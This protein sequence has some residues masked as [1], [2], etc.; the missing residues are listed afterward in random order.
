[1]GIIGAGASYATL[2]FLSRKN[3]DDTLD[4]FACHGVGGI[5]GSILTGVFASAT[6]NPGSAN[7][8]IYGNIDLMIPQIE[9]TLATI[10]LAGAGTALL[11]KLL[12]MTVGIRVQ[13]PEEDNLDRAQ[14]SESAYANLPLGQLV[15]QQGLASKEDIESCLSLQQKEE[16][17]K[18]LG[19]MLIQRGLLTE[20]LLQ[21]LLLTQALSH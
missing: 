13:S 19:S 5:V 11:L 1:M 4:V 2:R 16:N 8:L 18:P 3:L 6:V 12:D 17:P 21:Q 7:G 20:S 10:L 14:H 9:A 15:I